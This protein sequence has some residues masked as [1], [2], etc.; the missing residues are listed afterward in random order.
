MLRPHE[1]FHTACD[2]FRSVRNC[3][4]R[5]KSALKN[6]LAHCQFSRQ[7][8]ETQ[9]PAEKPS[10]TIEQEIEYC[11]KEIRLHTTVLDN[12]GV[13]M[14]VRNQAG[15]AAGVTFDQ[16]I[17]WKEEIAI[18]HHIGQLNKNIIRLIELRASQNESLIAE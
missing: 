13:M 16:T 12:L 3:K 4:D 10:M 2:L 17:C 7:A 9:R 6:R 14:A 15:S 8:P 11:E 5:I 1:A 18:R